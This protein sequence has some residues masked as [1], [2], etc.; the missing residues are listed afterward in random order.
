MHAGVKRLSAPH[1]S[2][3]ITGRMDD[4]TYHSNHETHP[5]GPR[6]MRRMWC[7]RRQA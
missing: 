4:T 3:S 6:S 2:A 1:S 5:P 7:T